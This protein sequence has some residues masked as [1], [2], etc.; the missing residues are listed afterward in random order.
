MSENKEHSY[1]SVVKK[2]LADG[3]ISRRE[4]LRTATLLGLSA[5]AAYGLVGEPIVTKAF[6]EMPK[7]GTIRIAQAVPALENPAQYISGPDSN[8]A[9]QVLEYLTKTG[10]DNITRPYLLESWHPSDDLKTWIL[11]VRKGVKWHKGRDFV[12]DDVI[13]NIK[14]KLDPA[15]G[16]SVLGLMK[17]YM[18]K[19]VEKDGKKTD[20]LWDSNAIEKVDDYTVRLNL[21]A[22]QVGVPEHFF[23]FPFL[24]LDPEEGGKFGVGSNGTGPFTMVEYQVGKIAA[25]EARKD[26]WGDG[27][28]IDRLEIVDFGN[29][30]AAH[31]NA[32]IS[33]QVHGLYEVSSTQIDVLEKIPDLQMYEI[34]TAN[35]ALVRGKVT[36][37]P[38]DDPRIMQAL[39]YA[40]DSEQVA[41]LVLRGRGTKGEHHPVAPVHP[42]YFPLPAFKPDLAKAK[43]LL[44]DAGFPDG[45]ESELTCPVE[46][47]YA[48][49]MVQSLAEQWKA[50]GVRVSL[51]MLPSSLY[52]DV[53]DRVALGATNWL[54]RPLGIMV[55]GLA[56][57]SGVPWN[58]SSF[59][60]AKFDELLIKAEGTLDVDKRRE[61]MADIEKIFQ[62][63]GPIV[64]PLWASVYTFYD[65]KVQGFKMHP[66]YYIFGNELALSPA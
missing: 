31:L 55:L 33:K 7:G 11:K 65:K 38:F 15:T 64:Q 43:Q 2:D 6:A 18:L 48:A 28:H 57:R 35:T 29:D 47:Y 36:E 37:K 54:H 26:Y 19:E 51:K 44:A 50:V 56:Y 61:I 14:Q 13:W 30:P 45:F 10:S 39:R 24:I 17:G 8:C 9:R 66:T 46:P 58:E 3:K 5:T 41:A 59:S 20:E 62:E 40:T 42:E 23:H 21:K 25:F 27:P 22:P 52:W 49:L 34:G 1:I 12:A 16:S 60:N 63:E 32:L 53:W 4:F